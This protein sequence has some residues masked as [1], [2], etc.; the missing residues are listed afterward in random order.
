M[1]NVAPSKAQLFAEAVDE[2]RTK[3]RIECNRLETNSDDPKIRAYAIERRRVSIGCLA[4]SL[5]L[6]D[7][8]LLEQES[9]RRKIRDDF[10][11]AG[12]I[13]PGHKLVFLNNS[14]RPVC[15]PV[16]FTPEA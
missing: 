11:K 8:A 7:R 16:H 6:H 13:L 14:N 1:M 12:M 2:W 15:V 5:L 4:A 10:E 3:Y 9:A